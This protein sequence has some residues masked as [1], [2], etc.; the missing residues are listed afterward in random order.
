[1][2]RTQRT[3]R[4]RMQAIRDRMMGNF[5]SPTLRERYR[6]L[7]VSAHQLSAESSTF[8]WPDTH[9]VSTFCMTLDALRKLKRVEDKVQRLQD[10][11]NR[12]KSHD[13]ECTDEQ[14]NLKQFK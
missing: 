5:R 6:K 3:Y 9:G 1:M 8:P 7:W 4:M 14:P 13:R 12:S 11:F 10:G 2:G